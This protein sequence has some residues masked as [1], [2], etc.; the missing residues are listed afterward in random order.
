MFRKLKRILQSFKSKILLSFFAFIRIFLIW[1]CVYFVI[2]YKQ[3]RLDHFTHHLTQLQFYY[4]EGNR[5]LQRFV[6]NG[7]HDP[8]F[9]TTGDQK[10]IAQF[11]TEQDSVTEKLNEIKGEAL[12]NDIAIKAELEQFGVLQQALLDS[13]KTLK[14]VYL[15]KGYKYAGAEGK[16]HAY[17]HYLED[18]S[19]ISKV[20]ILMLRRREKD[21]MLRGEQQYAD[22]VNTLADEQIR[23]FGTDAR[24]RAALTNYKNSF[25]EFAGYTRRIDIYTNDGAYGHVQA[26]I[27]RVDD[28]FITINAK[29]VKEVTGMR[30]LFKYILIAT[31]LFLLLAAVYL[32][33]VLSKRLTK[34]IKTLNSNLAL[35][36]HSGFKEDHVQPLATDITEL[37]ELDRDFQIL[38]QT[39]KKTLADY[40]ALVQQEKQIAAEH[41]ATI[42]MLR[43]KIAAMEQNS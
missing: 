10:D 17:A 26:I 1:I 22:D 28:H 32:T 5:Y 21:F 27:N 15:Q 39:L 14:Q 29:V 40:E 35:F 3:T 19:R 24:T 23:K 7:Y 36:V 33:I 18:S 38:K 41:E 9:Y 42:A 13:V 37:Q 34:D 25:N 11:F 31:F 8:G 4:A 6:L 2:N 30:S 20:D 16:V 43:A 12:S